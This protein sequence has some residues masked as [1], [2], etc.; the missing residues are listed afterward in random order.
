MTAGYRCEV[1]AGELVIHDVENGTERWRGKVAGYA[2]VEA[3]PIA[4]SPDCVVLLDPS[5]GPKVFSNLVRV[6]PN[7]EVAWR[8]STPESS[9]PDAYVEARFEEGRLVASSW[10]GF[11]CVVDLDDGSVE[12]STW[13]K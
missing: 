3:L 11:R 9:A 13:V 2:V 1:D 6:R 12:R 7:G 8:A 4:G 10:S 5:A